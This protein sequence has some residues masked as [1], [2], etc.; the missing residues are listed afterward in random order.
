MTIFCSSPMITL[1]TLHIC[2]EQWSQGKLRCNHCGSKDTPRPNSPIPLVLSTD[3][4]HT[5]GHPCCLSQVCHAFGD[6]DF[7]CGGETQSS[8][9]MFMDLYSGSETFPALFFCPFLITSCSN[10]KGHKS[11]LR[12]CGT[13]QD[14]GA[15]LRS[16]SKLMGQALAEIPSSHFRTISPQLL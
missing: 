12:T 15:G 9:F 14:H 11:A 1:W 13:P 8:R 7:G 6:E 16:R 3:T 4:S 10:R 2:W 5:G